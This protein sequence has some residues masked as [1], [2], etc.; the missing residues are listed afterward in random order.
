LDSF[1][2]KN[3]EIMISDWFFKLILA[4][5]RVVLYN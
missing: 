5:I 4:L 3:V 1:D 2:V